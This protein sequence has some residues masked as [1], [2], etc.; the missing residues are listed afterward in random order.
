MNEQDLMERLTA[1]V[2]SVHPAP[3]RLRTDP[4]VRSVLIE[5]YGRDYDEIWATLRRYF[6]ENGAAFAVVYA[7]HAGIGDE[8]FD[9]VELPLMLERLE[10]DTNRLRRVWPLSVLE[11]DRLPDLW[12][13]RA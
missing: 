7:L 11:Y 8:L 1:F 2:A 9:L 6:D 13:V 4:E 5:L 12:A 3:A 10:R